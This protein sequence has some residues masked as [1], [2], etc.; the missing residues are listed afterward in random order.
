MKRASIAIGLL[1]VA[2][3]ALAGEPRLMTGDRDDARTA[4]VGVTASDPEVEPAGRA[5][6]AWR[7]AS[8]SF[9]GVP[10]DGLTVT[11]SVAGD[12]Y[13]DAVMDG[14]GQAGVRAIVSVDPR[15]TAAQRAALVSLVQELSGGVISEVVRVEFAPVRFATT[16]KY[17]EVTVPDTLARVVYKR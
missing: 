12:V 10:L 3:S 15:A 9:D 1:L 14:E 17:V 5:I 16:S 4:V 8:G 2:Q 13:G 6:L 11:A 7:I